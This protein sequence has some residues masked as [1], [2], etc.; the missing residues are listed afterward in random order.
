MTAAR[1]ETADSWWTRY[2]IGT[3]WSRRR[4]SNP[5]P[6]VYKTA[7]LPIELHRRDGQGHT[8]DGPHRR[9][10]M[11]GPRAHGSSAERRP[12]SLGRSASASSS[13]STGRRRRA[14]AAGRRCGLRVAGLRRLGL[15][16][17]ASRRASPSAGVVRRRRRPWARPSPWRGFGVGRVAAVGG[18]GFAAALA[19][20][21]AVV[22]AAFAASASGGLG[23][24]VTR[25]ARSSARRRRRLVQRPSLSVVSGSVAFGVGL[26][27][28]LRSGRRRAR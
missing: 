23:G 10:G 9:R 18:L 22:A 24:A 5:E 27:L 26:R 7:A 21:G 6:A 16:C 17:G 12:A 3:R 19:R 1:V 28:R 8:A 20:V 11:I 13:G 25:A 2:R 4:D 14:F 15:R